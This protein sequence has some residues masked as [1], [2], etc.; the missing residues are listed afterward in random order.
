[1]S[2]LLKSSLLALLALLLTVSTQ[3]NGTDSSPSLSRLKADLKQVWLAKPA[4]RRQNICKMA[5]SSE[6]KCA[7]VFTNS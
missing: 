7:S 1:M 5:N 2:L 6:D 3:K 4:F